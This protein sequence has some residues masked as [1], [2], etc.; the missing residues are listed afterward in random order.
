MDSVQTKLAFLVIFVVVVFKKTTPK[1]LG[2]GKGVRTLSIEQILHR[3]SQYSEMLSSKNVHEEAMGR[4]V[5]NNHGV[6]LKQHKI[7]ELFTSF[8]RHQQ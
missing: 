5:V 1:D 8:R 7:V 4:L 6:C 3:A 2:L